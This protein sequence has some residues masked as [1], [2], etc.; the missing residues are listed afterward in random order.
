MCIHPTFGLWLRWQS[1][2]R[3]SRF[4]RYRKMLIARRFPGTAGIDRNP[5][6]RSAAMSRS[7]STARVR[8]KRKC[9]DPIQTGAENATRSACG[10]V[11]FPVRNIAVISGTDRGWQNST[12]VLCNNPRLSAVRAAQL[13]RHPR[14]PPPC[15]SRAQDRGLPSQSHRFPK[16]CQ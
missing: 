13:F 3:H 9:L 10:G 2:L 7:G 11:I 15:R 14:L 1:V 16:R 5:A 8:P 4:S 12:P 6:Q